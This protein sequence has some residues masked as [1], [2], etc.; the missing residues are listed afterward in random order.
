MR[1]FHGTNNRNQE[2]RTLASSTSFEGAE[3][4]GRFATGGRGG[5]VV[6]VTTSSDSG[7]GSFRWAVEELDGPRYVVFEVNEVDLAEDVGV[8]NGDVTIAGQTAGGVEIR[9]GAV[10]IHDSNVI[11][12]GLKIR[13]GDDPAGD[14]LGNRDALAIA[15]S[16]EPVADV[17][18]DHNSFQW[19]PDEVVYIGN[20]AQDVSLTNNIIAQ[21]L[22]DPDRSE[23]RYGKGL[24]L[25]EFS[26]PTIGPPSQVTIAKNLLAFNFDR[27]PRIEEAS[28]I[29]FINNFVYSPGHQ[30]WATDINTNNNEAASD[31]VIE[32]N[33]YKA[34]PETKRWNMDKPFVRNGSD[35]GVYVAGNIHIDKDGD[36]IDAQ[37]HGGGSVVGSPTFE[38]SRLRTLATDDVEAHVLQNAGAVP[39]ER[40]SVD[41]RIV[42]AA[43][44]EGAGIVG[45]PGE[46]G[47]YANVAFT[48]ARDSDDDG[49]PDWYED[50]QGLNKNAFDPN[51]DAD[52]NGYTNLEDYIFGLVAGVS[53]PDPQPDPE[54]EPDP[55]PD[56]EPEPDPQPDPEPDPG[57]EPG[58]APVI[59][60]VQAVS[61]LRAEE[62]TIDFGPVLDD[63]VVF[64][65]PLTL[66]GSGP[67][68]IRISGLNDAAVTL[69]VDEPNYLDDNH[70]TEDLS[71]LALERGVFDLGGGRRLEVGTVD[72][73]ALS[74]GDF[75]SVA[76]SESFED[77]PVVVAQIQTD[78]GGDWVV[79][80][81]DDVDTAGF[82]LAMQETEAKNNGGH[83]TETIGWLALEADVFDWA[84]VD[85]SVDTQAFTTDREVDDDG[86][87]F[88][89]A[90]AVGAAPRL[91]AGI[92]SFFGA[93]TTNLRLADLAAGTATFVADEERSADSETNH[94][95]ENVAGLAFENDALL[96]GTELF[97]G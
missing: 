79:P 61:D 20:N 89:F 94:T 40:D 5:D 84:T 90:A 87:S 58:S 48:P 85:G 13:P 36:R 18:V 88:D 51:A 26:N 9:G 25:H 15:D 17:M 95:T 38:G 65:T 54:P 45:S 8:A 59:G 50:R 68:T 92:A 23:I 83:V 70:T 12:Q 44:A 71:V 80:R 62:R 91:A 16:R 3:G 6:K 52:G 66:D 31:V 73:N 74:S 56:P 82:E 69:G 7:V 77:T 27:N 37:W 49:M 1:R 81:L 39:G 60:S 29:E 76:F 43:A 30:H 10:R 32:N 19:A 24:L 78:N 97:I 57:P 2:M 14:P 75:T 21:A 53:A 33:F 55:Q 4:F 63:P 64:A 47:G 72:S 86:T 93:D 34:G 42:D 46:A 22:N 35:D 11:M 41:R 96:T 28:K 67:A